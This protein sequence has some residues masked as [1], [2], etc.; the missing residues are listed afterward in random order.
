MSERQAAALA[1][2]HLRKQC[3]CIR[4]LSQPMYVE[5]WERLEPSVRVLLLTSRRWSRSLLLPS[6]STWLP[7]CSSS[8]VTPPR[9]ELAPAR[10][11]RSVMEYTTWGDAQL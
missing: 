1:G 2:V 7:P 6:S 11:A 10:E 3:W 5:D 8:A 9:M 4:Y